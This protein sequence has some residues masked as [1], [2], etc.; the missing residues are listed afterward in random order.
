MTEPSSLDGVSQGMTLRDYAR[1]ILRRSWLIVLIVVVATGSAYVLSARQTKMYQ[2]TAKIMYAPPL[3]SSNLQVSGQTYTD[4]YARMA[5]LQGVATVMSSPDMQRRGAA[6][7]KTQNP[8]AA[9]FTITAQ[10]QNDS[11]DSIANT[12]V[13]I[14]GTSS[15]PEV[16]RVAATAFAT[17]F[18]QWR[19]DTEI[20]QLNSEL[21]AL[22]PRMAA[23][24]TPASRETTDFYL[25]SQR[26]QALELAKATAT[27]NFTL[28]VPA[29]LPTT[30]YSP[31]PL[32]SG[33][34]G[35]GVSLFAALGLALLL[36][37]FDTRLRSPDEVA[38]I[39]GHPVI[40]RIPRMRQSTGK[41]PVP[42]LTSPNGPVAEAFR[43][44]RGNL[45]YMALDSD[46]HSLAVTS[47]LQGEG[48]SITACNLA[49]ATALVD[50]RV[51]LIE[52]DLRRP[53]LYEYFGLDNERGLASIV[54]GT[55]DL[56]GALQSVPLRADDDGS[57]VV[58]GNGLTVPNR[59]FVLTQ[60]PKVPNPG[61]I[62]ASGWFANLIEQCQEQADLVIVDTPAFLAVGD[63]AAI[64]G[65]VDGLV[66][67]VDPARAKRPVLQATAERLSNLPTRL[68]GAVVL[69]HRGRSAGYADYSYG[70]GYYASSPVEGKADSRVSAQTSGDEPASGNGN[71]TDGVDRQSRPAKS[72]KS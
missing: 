43:V 20:R 1:I 23:F 63:A 13:D 45:D 35:L 33:I 51:I 60:G 41:P 19:K 56:E 53:R 46:L 57:P 58:P 10:V 42:T 38:R 64:A 25:L 11:T 66:L 5:A 49:V 2:A 21:K 39:L 69:Q 7:V 36:E 14:M 3:D 26:V 62:V 27:G 22:R 12:V 28:V 34:L 70:S 40:G 59:L 24:L 32:R 17:A 65:A 48:K 52:G 29:A 54:T 61:E 72:A 47:S 44:L 4:P 6:L 16:A 18:I 15:T 9:G 8:A 71:R 67:V 30:P 31:R 50:R 55:H 37:Q 68:L